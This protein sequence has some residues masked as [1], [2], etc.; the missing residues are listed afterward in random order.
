MIH[1]CSLSK[2]HDVVA[3]TGAEHVVTLIRDT[4]R[5]TRPQGILE[6]N[7]LILSIDDIEDELDGMI[8]PAETHV[9][10]LI[11][12]VG[13]WKREKPIVVHCFAGI[14]RSTAAA[15]ITACSIYPDRDERDIARAI[16]NA[17]ATAQP[18]P[19]IVKFGDQLLGRQGRMVEA[20]R[21]IGK[22]TFGGAWIEEAEPFVIKI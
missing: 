12:F 17:S 7:H 11:D 4:T 21:G 15:F 5:V 1:V 22:G 10:D 16:R 19:R 13:R 9:A 2:M 6:Q 18:N 20:V 14:S 3:T 8:A